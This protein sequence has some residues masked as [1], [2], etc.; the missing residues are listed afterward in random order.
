M[1][2]RRTWDADLNVGVGIIDN[3][4]KII[5]DLIHDLDNV[6]RASADRRVADTLFDVLEN[7]VYRHFEAE[8]ELFHLH[9]QSMSHS[10]EHYDLVKQFRKFKLSFRN[11]K[12][13]GTEISTFLDTWFMDHIKSSDIPLFMQM[14]GGSIDLEQSGGKV[15][16]YPYEF[17]ER[18]RSKRIVRNKITDSEIVAACYNTSTLRNS[19]ATIVDISLGGAR[20]QT[21]VEHA[22]GDLLIINCTIG[23]NFHI[24][25]KVRVKNVDTSLY[26]TEFISLSPATEKFLVEL[27]GAVH[28]GNF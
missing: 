28:L 18:R 2:K 16:A 10:L 15:D 24:Q 12:D 14:A 19:T 26:G 21:P 6:T 22:V 23:K 17:K 11:K 9:E 5:F 25:E 27:Y 1:K 3:Q 7:Y 4:H 20:L 8:E 13:P